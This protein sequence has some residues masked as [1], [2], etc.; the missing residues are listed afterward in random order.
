M[1]KTLRSG[2]YSPVRKPTFTLIQHQL[3][4]GERLSYWLARCAVL[5]H[6]IV[7]FHCWWLH[8][9]CTGHSS[10]NNH[11]MG[12][13]PCSF[14]PFQHL[15]LKRTQTHTADCWSDLLPLHQSCKVTGEGERSVFSLFSG[16][17]LCV[18]LLSCHLGYWW[19]SQHSS[20]SSIS[21]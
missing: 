16:F 7:N 19:G 14:S 10:N 1:N 4:V 13:G 8:L 11:Q 12:H 2:L 17:T 21:C 15:C 20:W 5:C 18:L 6:A 9:Y 3:L